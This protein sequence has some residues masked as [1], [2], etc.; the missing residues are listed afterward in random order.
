MTSPP[1]TDRQYAYFRISGPGTHEEITALLG[2]R[3]SEAW[4]VGDMNPRTGKPRKFMSWRL[5][6]GLDDMHPLDEHIKYLLLWLKNKAENLRQ[7]WVEY[8]LTLQCVGYFAPSGHGVHFSRE[9]IRQ[10]AQLGLAFD[11]DFYYM[12]DHGHEI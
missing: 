8:D 11:L 2:L 7:L 1:L 12:D 10:A 6:S 4:N 5:G 3:P 9:T